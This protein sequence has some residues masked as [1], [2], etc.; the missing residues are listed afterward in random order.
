MAAEKRRLQPIDW[1][2]WVAIS[3]DL[4]FGVLALI[5]NEPY[6]NDSV[7][8]AVLL[9]ILYRYRKTL[10]YSATGAAILSLGWLFNMMGTIGAYNWYWNGVIGWDK[11][12]HITT[13]I[14]AALLAYYYLEHK[15]GRKAALTTVSI[16]VLTIIIVE[17]LSAFNEIVEFIGTAFFGAKV[18]T[19]SMSN[20][21]IVH[22][23]T[24]DKY[25]TQWDMIA[26][27]VGCCL[28]LCGLFIRNRFFPGKRKNSA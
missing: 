10:I 3:I 1:V 16:V 2:F 21:L 27:G 18:G 22:A 12:I 24:F 7:F 17:G 9:G 26:D 19:F 14:G 15:A 8:G 25:D 4:L 5:L 13:G 11:L 20:G 6:I 28:A 23:S